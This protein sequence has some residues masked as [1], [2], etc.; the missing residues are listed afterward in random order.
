MAIH[1]RLDFLA[2][3]IGVLI[4]ERLGTHDLSGRAK[5][6]LECPI[7]NKSLLNWMQ[8]GAV[9]Q[10]FNGRNLFPIHLQRQNGTGFDG[11]PFNDNGARSTGTAITSLMGS[12][13]SQHFP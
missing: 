5:S 1:G 11:F 3:W 4:Q 9:G 6:A 10:T 2:C 12:P 8:I 13:Q 7:V